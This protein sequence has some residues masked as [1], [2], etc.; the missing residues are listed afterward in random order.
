MWHYKAT[1]PVPPSDAA[2]GVVTP[3]NESVWR[4]RRA[5]GSIVMGHLCRD[6][7]VSQRP[8]MNSLVARI[9][10]VIGLHDL[11]VGEGAHVCIG[12]A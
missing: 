8:D 5:G 10:V 9:L 2:E 7:V 12:R 4:S 11:R 6:R 3:N 1:K